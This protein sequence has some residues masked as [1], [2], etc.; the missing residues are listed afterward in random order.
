[1]DEEMI[2]LELL[3]YEYDGET[4]EA[5][6]KQSINWIKVL[7]Y[8]TYHRVAGLVYDKVNRVNVRLLDYPVFFTSY[9]INQSKAIRG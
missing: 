1:M 6:K 7:G 9:L 2:V 3:K 5:L 4:I 8:L